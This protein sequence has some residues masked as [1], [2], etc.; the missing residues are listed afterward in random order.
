MVGLNP[1]YTVR[2]ELMWWFPFFTLTSLASSALT[3]DITKALTI[4][5]GNIFNLYVHQVRNGTTS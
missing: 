5:N 4:H 1:K 3:G 2:D